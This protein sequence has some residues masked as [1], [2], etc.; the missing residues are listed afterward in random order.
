MLDTHGIIG[1]TRLTQARRF[2]AARALLYHNLARFVGLCESSQPHSATKRAFCVPSEVCMLVKRCRF[3]R[4]TFSVYPSKAQR[5]F[6]SVQC[7]E[8]HRTGLPQL[9]KQCTK[10]HNEYPAT[11]EYFRHQKGA[12]G[13]LS[14]EC[15]QCL[16]I[17]DQEYKRQ[18]A[19][20]IRRDAREYHKSHPE[21][22]KQTKRQHYER[23]RDEVID[24]SRQYRKDNPDYWKRSPEKEAEKGS[25]RRARKR[26]AQGVFT[27]ADVQRKL[28]V[29]RG[30]CFYCHKKLGE[31]Y[32]VDHY[33]PLSR[34]GTNWPDNIVIACSWCNLTKGDRMPVDFVERFLNVRA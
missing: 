6:C 11:T 7:R 12:K 30:R 33:I 14:S 32:H 9:I 29:Q 27:I 8:W 21:W 20:K 16:K 24:K 17:R 23:H 22:S 2:D 19:S 10:C 4:K 26:Q 1:L 3:C 31:S 18:N 13:N 25:K 5:I 15:L 28:W 34:G